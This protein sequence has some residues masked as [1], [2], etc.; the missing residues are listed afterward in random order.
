MSIDVFDWDNLK[1]LFHVFVLRIMGF[2][3]FIFSA[4]AVLGFHCFVC[5]AASH[6]LLTSF[7]DYMLRMNL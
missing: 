6:C 5:I 4:M 2:S 3:S 7:D 1:I